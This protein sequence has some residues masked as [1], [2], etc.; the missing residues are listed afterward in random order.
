MG[1][2][3]VESDGSFHLSVPAR[4]SLRLQTLDGDGQVL[5]A[6]RSW[7]WVMPKEARGCIG[8]HVDRVLSPPTRHALALWKP[9]HFIGVADREVG[10]AGGRAAREPT[11]G[12]AR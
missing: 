2:V 8:C 7:I 10:G 4:T 11:R 6:M 3:P 5:Q 12:G 1:T 9:P